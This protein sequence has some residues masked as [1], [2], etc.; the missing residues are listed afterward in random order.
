MSAVSVK[1]TRMLSTLQNNQKHG[2]FLKGFEIKCSDTAGGPV[3]AEQYCLQTG[4]SPSENP[5]NGVGAS[6]VQDQDFLLDYV[7]K[8]Q[9]A[10]E[11]RG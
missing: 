1:D 5:G 7:E 10:K 8:D 9:G 4:K 11:L 2:S 6:C 3:Q